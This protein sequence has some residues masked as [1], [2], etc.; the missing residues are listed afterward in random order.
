ML[1]KI[2]LAAATIA[3][4]APALAEDV[5][6]ERFVHEGYTY[7]YKVKP[8]KDG[9]LITGTRYPGA[10]AFNLKVAGD[11][12]HGISDGTAVAF[13]LSEARGASAAGN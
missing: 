8:T 2:V 1:S 10:T 13:N 12:V 3:A 4:A 7:V 9:K 6:K 5:A 11:K